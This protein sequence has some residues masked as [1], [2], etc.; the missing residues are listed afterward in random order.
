MVAAGGRLVLE[1][2]PADARARVQA[3][4][5]EMLAAEGATL[6]AARG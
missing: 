4:G 6:V 3:A 1:P 5:L 2:A